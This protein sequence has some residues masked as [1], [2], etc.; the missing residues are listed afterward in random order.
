MTINDLCKCFE[1]FSKESR[2]LVHFATGNTAMYKCKDGCIGCYKV[3]RLNAVI[4]INGVI[5]LEIWN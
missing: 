3:K 5:V 4:I 1:G 2:I